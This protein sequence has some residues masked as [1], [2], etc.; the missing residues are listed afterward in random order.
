MTKRYS[1]QFKQEAL[2]FTYTELDYLYRLFNA[3][4]RFC[5]IIW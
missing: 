1:A 2:N 4:T 5:T 3:H